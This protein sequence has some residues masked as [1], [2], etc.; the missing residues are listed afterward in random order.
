MEVASPAALLRV[1]FQTG[2][3]LLLSVKLP[4]FLQRGLTS[5]FATFVGFVLAGCAAPGPDVG[6]AA[7]QAL[8]Q[9]P[10][11]VASGAPASDGNWEHLRFPGKRANTYR[12]AKLDGREAMGVE[13]SSSISMLRQK[14]NIPPDQLHHLHF[15]WKVPA[16]IESAD[17]R[18]GDRSDSP[19][20]IVL[21]FEGN[22]SKFS[23]RDAMLSELAN[24]LTGEPMPYA[25]LMYV[26]GNHVQPGT[27]LQNA[28]TGRIRKL[29]LESG[30]AK[31]SR[32]LDYERD[33]RADFIRAFGEAPGTLVSIGIM[34][35]CDN[36]RSKAKAW[37]GPVRHVALEAGPSAVT[38]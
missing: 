18:V 12:Y 10:W 11:A 38:P 22:R 34:T 20:R 26:W 28:R 24:A 13:A 4:S 8:G 16:L 7:T 36:T 19:V 32:W 35:D 23:A 15:S 14:V 1:L 30:P 31:L 37:Y 33:I 29:V 17:L 9:S 6:S 5:L 21:A 3:A 27:V 25:T 2:P